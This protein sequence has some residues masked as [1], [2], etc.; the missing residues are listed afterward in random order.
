[1]PVYHFTLH[2]YRS[3]RPDHPRG[4]T[5]RGKGYQAPSAEEAEKHDERAAQPPAEFDLETQR[6]L[7]RFAH[8]FCERRKYRLHAVG[9]EIGHSH[10]VLSWHG[11]S[12]WHE[13]M[14]RLKNVLTMSLNKQFRTPR[15]KWFVRGG[16]RKRVTSPTHLKHLQTRYLP[17]HPG[18]CWCD[19]SPLP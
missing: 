9:N 14:R 11:F 16:S 3:W 12:D 18:L 7:I 6:L 13:V 8:D 5:K 10:Y 19:G 4:Y 15:R 17:N 1:M 2:A